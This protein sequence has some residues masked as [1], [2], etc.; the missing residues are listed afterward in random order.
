MYTKT[1]FGK[2]RKSTVIIG[3]AEILSYIYNRN[4]AT[5]VGFLK[6]SQTP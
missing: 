4:K 2:W 3:D 1:M 6:E 5:G